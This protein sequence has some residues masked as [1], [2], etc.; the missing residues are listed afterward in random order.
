MNDWW[1]RIVLAL[2]V[3]SAVVLV[4][5]VVYR[6][7]MATFEG[8]VVPFYKAVQVVVESLTTA[9]FGGH[10]PWTTLPLNLLVLAMNLTGVLLVFL[11]LP[12]FA[13]PMF[14]QVLKSS[15]PTS[16]D[17]TD[18]VII[19]SYTQRDE[20]L[21]KELE[22][23]R[24]PYLFVD[25]DPELVLDLTDD[26]I[27]AIH[28]DPEQIGTLQAANATEARALV[29]DVDDETNPTV[30]ISAKRVNPALKVVSVVRDYDVA[31]YHQYAGADEVVQ[32]RQQLGTSLAMRAMTSF[33]EKLRDAIEVETELEITELIIEEGSDLVGQTLEEAPVFDR[34]DVNVVGAWFGGKFVVSPDPMTPMEEN[35]ILLVAGRHEEIENI[36]ARPI[37]AH[38][39][40]PSRVLVCGYGT[41][42]WVV[43]ETLRD[44]GIDVEVVDLEK[45]DGVDI[46][47]DVTDPD[48][49]SKVDLKNARTVVLALD[50]DVP[51]IYATLVIRQ[52]TSDI[53]IVAR[54]DDAENVWK[55]YNAGA[56]FVLSLPTVTGEILASILI[57]EKAIL[58]ARSEFEFERTDAPAITGRSLAEVDLRAETGCTV[59]AA[60]RDGQLVTDLGAEFVV[61]EEDVIVVAGTEESIERFRELVH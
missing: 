13:I 31:P 57:D 46:V 32:S 12:V 54:A 7:A 29:A 48:T 35:T 14:R 6:W 3:V 41:V 25:R 53:E 42:G 9:G 8:E 33:S 45:R 56:D 27:D 10:A 55:L 22:A 4:Y 28:G 17:L 44:E 40:H 5:A 16:S 34:P 59:V 52:L 11:A 23:A 2:T 51:T 50:E 21:R 38:R 1:R 15:P 18:H 20:V 37:P 61:E 30:I 24:I 47:G 19:C 49:L 60:E 36:E 58:T 39:G 43:A 26:G